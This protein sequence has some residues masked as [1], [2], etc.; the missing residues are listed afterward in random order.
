MQSTLRVISIACI[1]AGNSPAEQTTLSV[2]GEWRFQLDG[3]N[4]GIEGKWFTRKLDD[5][6]ILP[7]TTDT[8]AKGNQT[9]HRPADRLARKWTWIGPAWYQHD[10]TIPE[11]WDGKRVTLFFERSRNTRVWINDTFVGRDDSLSAPHIFDVTAAM[12]P[13]KHTITVMIDN[14]KLPPVGPAHAVDERTQTNWNGIVGAMELRATDPVWIDDVQVFPNVAERT[15]RVVATIGNITGEPASGKITTT[16]ES[17]NVKNPT[18]FPAQSLDFQA[19]EKRNIIEFTYNPGPEVPL[20]DEFEPAMVRLSLALEAGAFSHTKSV[21]FGMREFARDGNR[22]LLNG[23]PVH[24]RGRIDC[25]NYPLTGF[26]PMEK[27]EWQRILQI[28]KDWGLN[29][30]RYHSWCP[31]AAAFEVAD[32]LGLLLQPELPN[33]RSAFNAPDEKDQS[34]YNIDFMELEAVDSSVSL[35]DFAKREGELIFRHYGNSPS[36]ILFTL[37]NELG[38]NDGMAEMVAHFQKV[39]PRALHAQGAN[40]MHWNPTLP[41]GDDFWLIGKLNK[42]D[43]PLRGSFA[44]H[45]YPNPHIEK[46]PPSTMVNYSHTIKGVPVPMIGHETGQFQVSPDFRE[47]EQFTGVLEA[48]N[49]E[50]FRDRVEAAGMLDQAH[51]MFEASGAL[52]VICYREDIEAAL[53][54]RELGGFQLLDLQDFPGQ[55]TALVGLLNVFMESKGLIDPAKW[56]E[57]CSETVPLFLMEKY[58]WTQNE[59][60]TGKIQIAHYGAAD[61]KDAV[62]VAS[63]ADASGETIATTRFNAAAVPTGHVTDIGAFEVDLASA[64]LDSAQKL[65]LTLEILGTEIRNSYPVWVYP[66]KVDTRAP[67]GIK[68]AREFLHGDTQAHLE[69]GGKVLLLPDI[70]KLPRSIVGQFQNEFWSPM[71]AQSSRRREIL[72]PP[73]TLGLMCDPAHPA[74]AHFPTEF[75]SNWQWWHLVRNSRPLILDATP[76]D[77]RPIVQMIDNFERNHKLGI[78]METKVG[79]GSMLVCTIDLQK[80]QKQPEARQFLHSLLQYMASD[81]FAPEHEVDLGLIKT[82]LP[83]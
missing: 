10:V 81:G 76:Q 36:F 78:L 67:E 11:S 3:K 82:L 26:A 23:R 22:L 57:F 18:A 1:L 13:G 64:K 48:R 44:Y 12:K 51:A 39:N 77:Y 41:E 59:K 46:R 27:A 28:H 69:A 8:N 55:G 71:F 79:K 72:D 37:G 60:F 2:A 40:N 38:M 70:G 47:I 30:I 73:G 17:H 31:P 14:S 74:L 32:G 15:A 53:R 49:Y 19:G 65:T 29:H 83:E 21:S 7:G 43:K 45:D 75:H 42:E 50:I 25:A 68:V 63:L 58:T 33:K 80:I 34:W 16:S 61:M 9:T 20:W 35:Y 56:R 4:E 6:V 5:T 54:T 24:L 52:A 66:A 62:V